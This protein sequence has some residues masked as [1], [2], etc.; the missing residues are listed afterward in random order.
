V[1]YQIRQASYLFDD[2][3]LVN[4][5][6]ILVLGNTGTTLHTSEY[7]DIMGES[8]FEAGKAVVACSRG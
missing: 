2:T 7:C 5:D 6:E 3:T 1:S 4:G 8:M